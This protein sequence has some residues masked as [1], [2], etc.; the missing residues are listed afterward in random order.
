MNGRFADSLKK[1]LQRKLHDS[2]SV[3]RRYSTELRTGGVRGWVTQPRAVC[4]VERLRSKLHALSFPYLER[5]R[6]ARI[7]LELTRTENRVWT[8]IAERA[9]GG[10]RK[11]RRIEPVILR[12][13]SIH[14]REYLVGALICDTA[15]RGVTYSRG[16]PD[17]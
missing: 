16:L 6:Q 13:V 3:L 7:E 11:G 4:N 1:I 12:L 9:R 2:R 15:E 5:S 17:A 8:H 10:T 14:I